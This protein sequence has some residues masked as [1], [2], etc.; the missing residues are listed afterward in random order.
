V[1]GWLSRFNSM[2][3]DRLGE[4]AEPA[5]PGGA[6]GD[7][8]DGADRHLRLF[9]ADSARDLP[10]HIRQAAEEAASSAESEGNRDV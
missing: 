2:G 8:R 9:V 7:R 4:C 1:L 10:D 3:Q 5:R 6:G